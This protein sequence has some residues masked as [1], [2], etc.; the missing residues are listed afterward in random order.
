MIGARWGGWARC[1]TQVGVGACASSWLWRSRR[2]SSKS[3]RN[4]QGLKRDDRREELDS[5]SD[6]IAAMVTQSLELRLPSLSDSLLLLFA[7][8]GYGDRARPG[9]AKGLKDSLI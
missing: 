8:P 1:A 4:K 9:V 5:E 3:R 2:L 7:I 6:A